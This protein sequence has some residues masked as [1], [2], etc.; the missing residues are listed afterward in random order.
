M[1]VADH[2]FKKLV[3]MFRGPPGPPGPQGPQGLVGCTGAIGMSGPPGATYTDVFVE[4]QRQFPL[5]SRKIQ[6]LSVETDDGR[7]EGISREEL[8]AYLELRRLAEENE[9]VNAE[10]ERLRMTVKMVV[11]E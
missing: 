11:S 3:E 10:L 4:H 8:L 1:A 9:L 6:T 2:T 7:L 5:L